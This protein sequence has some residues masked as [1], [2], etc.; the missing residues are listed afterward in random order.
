MHT[1]PSLI[2]L[3]SHSPLRQHASPNDKRCGGGVEWMFAAR[4]FLPSYDFFLCSHSFCPFWDRKSEIFSL[5]GKT[6]SQRWAAVSW[7]EMEELHFAVSLLFPVFRSPIQRSFY[8]AL[9]K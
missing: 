3:S 1:Y 5:G 7:E 4:Q 9:F 6:C 8:Y 2:S